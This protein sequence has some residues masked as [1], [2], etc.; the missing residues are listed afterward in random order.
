MRRLRQSISQPRRHGSQCPQCPPNQPTPT[1][2]PALQPTTPAPTASITPAI[3]CPGMR[4]KERS[5]PLPFDGETVAM[6]HA[7]SLD[8]DANL[9]PRRLGRVALDEF[10]RAA[11]PRHLHRPHFCHRCLLA[12]SNFPVP[13]P[14][15][16]P[17]FGAVRRLPRIASDDTPYIKTPCT[18]RR[19]HRGRGCGHSRKGHDDPRVWCRPS[20]WAARAASP[21]ATRPCEHGSSRNH[22]LRGAAASN[23]PGPAATC[24]SSVRQ[25]GSPLGRKTAVPNLAPLTRP[26]LSVSSAL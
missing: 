13:S 5:G 1:R 6:A 24:V 16:T 10:K 19:T 21:A 7:A 25:S 26:R 3:S 18:I 22:R 4:G 11:R 9:A 8:A 15:P 2:C 23:P 20:G 17:A 12:R 14:P